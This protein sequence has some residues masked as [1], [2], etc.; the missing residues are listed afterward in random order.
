MDYSNYSKEVLEALPFYELRVIGRNAGIKS[1]TTLKKEEL[2]SEIL[3]SH[4]ITQETEHEIQVSQKKKKQGRPPKNGKVIVFSDSVTENNEQE[5]VND[6]GNQ[7]EMEDENSGIL[8]GIMS[9]ALNAFNVVKEE[10]ST[11][12]HKK[13]AVRQDKKTQLKDTTIKYNISEKSEK[14]NTVSNNLSD[15]YQI[16][17]NPTIDGELEFKEGVLEIMQDGYGFLRANNYES[18][19]KDAY[20]SVQKIKKCGLKKG[21]WIKAEAKKTCENRPAGVVNVISVNGFAPENVVKRKHFDYLTPIYPDSRFRLEI[22]GEKND[23]AI[24]SIDLVAPIG[25][26][27]RAM[28]VS[29]PKAGKTT[30]LKKVANSISANYPEA[31]LIVLLIDE[32]P[33]EVTDMQR[34]IKG[35]VVY[36]TFDEMPEH[37]TKAAELVLERAKRLVEMGKDVV[38]LMDSLTRLARAYNLTIAPTGRTLSGGI[39]PGALHSPKRFFG[40]ARN[41]ENG[42]SLTIIATALIDTGSRMDDVIYEEFK[43]TGN[44]EIHL[45]RRLTEKR[46]FPAIDLNRSGTRREELLLTQKELET[47]WGMR[48][49]LNAGDGGDASEIMISELVKTK[50]NKEFMEQID[51]KIKMMQ[52]Q[53][54]WKN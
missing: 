18:G 37:H 7:T 25:K 2:I 30:L 9:E 20:I 46:I 17:N 24:R 6:E 8:N 43:G 41:I 19:E 32:R 54:F 33:E 4:Y 35:E 1:P 45:D 48:R 3:N 26:G 50:T 39:D 15:E 36:S 12:T 13:N 40:A 10:H 28:I 47:V 21:D 53:G 22:D 38:I 23:F 16:D 11:K 51:M 5:I 31:H 42:G 44:M 49:M 27:Q 14:T 52:Q 29:P 34:S